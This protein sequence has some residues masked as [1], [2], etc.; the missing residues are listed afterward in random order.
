MK[1][2][3]DDLIMSVSMALYVG[4][5]AY[6]QLEKVNEQT[7][8]M[9]SSWTVADDSTNREITK[10][11]PGMP[12]LSPTGYNDAFSSNPTKKDYEQYLWLFGKR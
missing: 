3:H 11:N 10:F 5:N 1:G 6:N 2:H 4:Q 7:K 8:A 12:V 9:L